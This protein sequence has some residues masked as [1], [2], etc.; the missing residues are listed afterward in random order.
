VK[1]IHFFCARVKRFFCA[2]IDLILTLALA[3][4][5]VC[6]KI[7]DM[8]LYKGGI[9]NYIAETLG[10]TVATENEPWAG[11]RNLQYFLTD[12]Y[13]IKP[14]TLGEIRCLLVKPKN[15]MAAVSAVKKHLQT[16]AGQAGLPLVL[17][18]E[19]LNAKQRKA[20]I[21]AR[22]PFVVDGSQLY[23]PFLG[24]AL[25]ERYANPTKQVETLSPTAQLVLFRYLYQGKRELYANGLAEFFGVSAMQI[26]RA[27]RQMVA[28]ELVATRKDGVQIVI[29]GAENAKPLFDKAKPYLLNPVR[30][31]FFVDNNALPP[32]LPLAGETALGEYTMLSAPRVRT[33]AYNG[34]MGDFPASDIL[35]DWE[36]Q[37]QVEVWWYSPT[38]LSLKDGFADPLSLWAAIKNE[39][40]DP[41]LEMAKDELLDGIWRNE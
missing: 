3:F 41:R 2:H 11:A 31:R 17:V 34:K 36:T 13:S 38:V 10:I 12:A 28:L 19:T 9:M 14:V 6:D 5:L 7:H 27:V 32:N 37:S 21:A 40:D 30:K 18:P 8:M 16:I 39:E 20:L 26:T 4:N 29:T 22:I 1:S 15:N 24:A 25:Q 33:Y 23:L 35:V